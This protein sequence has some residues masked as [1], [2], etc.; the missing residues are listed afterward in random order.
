[1]CILILFYV[2][3]ESVRFGWTIVTPIQS[4]LYV[5]KNPDELFEF[6]TCEVVKDQHKI[7]V[8]RVVI[9]VSGEKQRIYVKRYNS[10]SLRQRFGSA[11]VPSGGVKS[12]RGA[13]ILNGKGIANGE[14]DRGGRGAQTRNGS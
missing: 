2:G 4:S 9:D 11:F 1:M 8:A 10:F 12:L 13:A 7:K 6:P 3:K 5:L 14:A